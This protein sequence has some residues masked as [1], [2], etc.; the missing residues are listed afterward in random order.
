VIDAAWK[1]Q[2]AVE[3]PLATAVQKGAD[4]A[5]KLGFLQQKPDLTNLFALETLNKV[6]KQEKLPEAKSN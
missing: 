2:D 5:Y 1:N 3:D 4:N 6:L